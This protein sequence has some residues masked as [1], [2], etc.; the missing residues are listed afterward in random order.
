MI[1]EDILT[2]QETSNDEKTRDEP[3]E[4]G[5]PHKHCYFCVSVDLCQKK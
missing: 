5:G 2:H 1:P 3:I 4:F